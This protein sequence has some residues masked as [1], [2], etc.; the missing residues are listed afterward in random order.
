MRRI[1]ESEA[2][3]RDDDE[4]FAPGEK[5]R[6]V[7][8]QALRSIDSTALSDR[9]IPTGLRR[10]AISVDVSTPRTEYPE[11]EPVPFSVTMKNSLPL[12]VTVPTA[13]P[14]L[15]TWTVDGEREASRVPVHE[16]PAETGQFRFD[17]GE[18][19]EFRKRWDQMF[20][21]SESEWEP[22][23]PG[24]YTIGAGINVEASDGAALYD[25]TIVRVVPE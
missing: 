8:L 17:R 2:L 14:I 5:E 7:R 24:E 22:A 15:W 3:H 19:K 1:Y 21:V 16:P 10:R 9:L 18:R 12:P 6:S 13:S 25:E 11:G 20:R 4:A 23:A